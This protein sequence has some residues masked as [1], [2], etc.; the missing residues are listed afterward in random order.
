ARTPF[1]GRLVVRTR[2]PAFGGVTDLFES[3]DERLLQSLDAAHAACYRA[4]SFGGPSLHF[5]LR[6]RAAGKSADFGR[7]TESVYAFRTPPTEH[8]QSVEAR[9]LK[10]GGAWP[11]P[12]G[13][14]FLQSLAGSARNTSLGQGV[15]G[16]TGQR[17]VSLLGQDVGSSRV[18][19]GSC[20]I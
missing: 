7:Y 3:H 5:H 10:K 19:R 18:G 9:G 13:N 15:P 4:G 17:H 14:P 16:R 2:M 8:A 11:A 1:R 6:A 20:P 12:R